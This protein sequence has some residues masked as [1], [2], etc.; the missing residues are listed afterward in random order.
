MLPFQWAGP[1]RMACVHILCKDSAGGWLGAGYPRQEDSSTESNSWRAIWTLA[2]PR[3]PHARE[4]P[5]EFILI[6]MLQQST[7]SCI[8]LLLKS[9]QGFRNNIYSCSRSNIKCLSSWE[10]SLFKRCFSLCSV[11]F[12]LSIIIIFEN[13]TFLE[14]SFFQPWSWDLGTW[15]PGS[16]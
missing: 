15:L 1:S 16:V 6:L 13:S 9:R 11:S 10:K 8:T 2:N 4:N 7:H 12:L 14:S 3:P 5:S